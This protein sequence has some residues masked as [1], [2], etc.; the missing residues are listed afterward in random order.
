MGAVFKKT[1]TKPLPAGAEFFIRKGQR[2][3]RWKDAKGKT[4]TEPVTKGNDGRGRLLVTA[5]TFTAKYRDGANH[6]VEVATGCR[7]ETAAR[8]VLHELELRADKVRSK[9]RTADE[10][11]VIDN[12]ATPLSVHVV[13]FLEHQQAKGITKTE[14]ENTRARLNRLAAEC[15]FKQLS[16]LKATALERWLVARQGDGMGART[17][18]GYRAAAVVFCNWCVRNQRLLSNPFA[19]V[20]KADEQADPRRKRRAMS[21]IELGQLLTVATLRPL[22]EFGRLTVREDKGDVQRQRDTWKRKPLTFDEL[23]AAVE[24]ARE[25]LRDNPTLMAKRNIVGA[26]VP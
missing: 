12:L 15:Q 20:P 13:A 10:D 6:V 5:G 8:A 19:A 2:F 1:F 3:A 21:E 14:I 7:D 18:N 17:R 23:V 16:S 4:R 25:R 9:L 24:R 11:A 22:A 26:N